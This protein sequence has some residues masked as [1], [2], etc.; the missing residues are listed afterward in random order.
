M[1]TPWRSALPYAAVVVFFAWLAGTLTVGLWALIDGYGMLPEGS[2][3]AE[4]FAWE[5]VFVLAAVGV[6]ASARRFLAPLPRWRAVLV[7]GSL[8][9]VVKV[10]AAWGEMAFAGDEGAFGWAMVALP[11]GLFSLEFPVAWCLMAWRSK[12]LQWSLKPRA[13]ADLV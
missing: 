9:V 3:Y 7:D 5:A 13:E 2:S 12:D 8:Y 1:F 10:A 6:V 11:L 4:F